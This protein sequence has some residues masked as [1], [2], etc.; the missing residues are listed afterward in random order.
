MIMTG[1]SAVLILA[2]YDINIFALCIAIYNIIYCTPS[3]VY[4]EINDVMFIFF[5]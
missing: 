5:K 4:G 1:V 2:E 3:F